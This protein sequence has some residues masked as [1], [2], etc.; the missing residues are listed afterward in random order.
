MWEEEDEGRNIKN[1]GEISY[2]CRHKIKQ[3]V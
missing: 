3:E 2:K 1:S